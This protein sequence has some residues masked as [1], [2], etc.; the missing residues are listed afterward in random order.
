MLNS[1]FNVIGKYVF[2]PLPQFCHFVQL[3]VTWVRKSAKGTHP[4]NREMSYDEKVTHNKSDTLTDALTHI[5]LPLMSDIVLSSSSAYTS[6][7]DI[8]QPGLTPLQ[9]NLDDFIDIPGTLNLPLCLSV[10]QHLNL[11]VKWNYISPDFF[12]FLHC[13]FDLSFILWYSI[14]YSILFGPQRLK[15][16]HQGWAGRI[17]KWKRM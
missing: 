11:N 17:G 3:M 10:H 2:L 12:F 14:N 15:A 9:P 4:T 1:F 5:S 7:A 8:I 16:G 13:I 6:N